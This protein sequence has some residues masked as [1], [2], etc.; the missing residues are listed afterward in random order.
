[1]TNKA[2]AL[3]GSGQPIPYAV[4]KWLELFGDWLNEFN[5]IIK[6]SYRNREE[7]LMEWIG[8]M[9]GTFKSPIAGNT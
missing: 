2:L 4:Q 1:L 3:L 6:G 9:N 7:L 5:F 8:R